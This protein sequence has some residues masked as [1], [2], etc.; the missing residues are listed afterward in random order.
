MALV[1]NHSADTLGEA[2]RLT[3]ISIEKLEI[4]RRS[5]IL[6]GPALLAESLG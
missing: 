6:G 1:R 5:N 4:D 2:S 3:G